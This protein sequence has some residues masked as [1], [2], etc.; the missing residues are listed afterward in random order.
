MLFRVKCPAE[1]SLFAR[2]D[3][4]P[5]EDLAG[6]IIE[7]S[8]LGNWEDA[9]GTSDVLLA[10]SEVLPQESFPR[11]RESAY[12][13]LAAASV[14]DGQGVSW[15]EE[16]WDT[17]FAV[18]ALCRDHSPNRVLIEQGA[19]WLIEAY[20]RNGKN[21]Y[22]EPWET[23]WALVAMHDAISVVPELRASFDPK[24]VLNW[25]LSLLDS[26]GGVLVNHHYTAQFLIAASRWL[27]HPVM[28]EADSE[29]SERIQSARI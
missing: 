15:G 19:R 10:L 27:D 18:I 28:V 3:E 25:L 20:Q 4:R 8:S 29:L 13:F 22:S 6:L 16:V 7:G 5:A 11:L 26:R 9:R 24:P 12:E 17:A 1:S 2:V 21:W 23:L 14:S